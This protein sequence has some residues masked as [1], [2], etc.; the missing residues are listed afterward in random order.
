MSLQAR[1][2]WNKGSL[3]GLQ[4]PRKVGSEVRNVS[5]PFSP[6]QFIAMAIDFAILSWKWLSKK[7]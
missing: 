1:S 2:L 6:T 7:S 4:T 5:F 3:R